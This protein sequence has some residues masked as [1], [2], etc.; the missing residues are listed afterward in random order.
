MHVIK[1]INDDYRRF[2]KDLKYR[3]GTRIWCH[4]V[5]YICSENH[6]ADPK[7]QPFF[8]LQGNTRTIRCD[9]AEHKFISPTVI[10][11]NFEDMTELSDRMQSFK[12][13]NVD[14]VIT[15]VQKAILEIFDS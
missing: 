14:Y 3:T 5:L 11:I 15:E 10:G 6:L 2:I 8:F 13:V 1:E 9:L 7:T 12:L 4:G